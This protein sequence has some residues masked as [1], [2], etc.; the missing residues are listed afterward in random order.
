MAKP[1]AKPKAKPVA[2]AS[3]TPTP[4]LEEQLW[5]QCDSCAK[6]R[7]LPESMRDSDELEDAW[8]CAMHPDPTRRGCE[9][10][11]EGL[12]EDEVTTQVEVEQGMCGTPGCKYADFHFGPCSCWEAAEEGERKKRRRSLLGDEGLAS[13]TASAKTAMTTKAEKADKA[14]EAAKT[15]AKTAN[16]TAPRSA[17]RSAA[18]TPAKRSRRLEEVTAPAGHVHLDRFARLSLNVGAGGSVKAE[19][20]ILK[21]EHTPELSE[22]CI[23]GSGYKG[24]H[25]VQVGDTIRYEARLQCAGMLAGKYIGRFDSAK[26]AA[27]AH[28]RAKGRAVGPRL[29]SRTAANLTT[30][31]DDSHCEEPG[32]TVNIR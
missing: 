18:S 14:A 10:A 4:R 23:E 26:E 13:S 17:A 6:W 24:V 5:V 2:R 27:L 9:V 7:R 20:L 30:V 11:E 3:A 32:A 19:L 31:L 1:K 22:G 16:N 29:K 28:A 21:E 15:T 12:G 25:K 8:A